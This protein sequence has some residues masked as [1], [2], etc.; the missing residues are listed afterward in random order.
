MLDSTT[1]TA[2]DYIAERAKDLTDDALLELM[3]VFVAIMHQWHHARLR[4]DLNVDP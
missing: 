3:E 4:V 1:K 2:Q